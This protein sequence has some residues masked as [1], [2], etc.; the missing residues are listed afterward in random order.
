LIRE[1]LKQ[2]LFHYT[3]SKK[4]QIIHTYK[5]WIKQRDKK[6]NKVY[7]E[8]EGGNYQMIYWMESIYQEQ[9]KKEKELRQK[10]QIGK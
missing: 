9:K 6:A 2:Y 1:N 10:I 8:S 7:R 4:E 3:V 5:L